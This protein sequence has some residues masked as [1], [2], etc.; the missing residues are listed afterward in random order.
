MF[1]SSLVPSLQPSLWKYI[2]HSLLVPFTINIF[3]RL[4][5]EEHWS[6]PLSFVSSFNVVLNLNHCKETIGLDPFSKVAYIWW[7]AWYILNNINFRRESF[8]LRQ[9]IESIKKFHK[10]WSFTKFVY[11]VNL[12][13]E[14]SP[15][16]KENSIPKMDFFA[17]SL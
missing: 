12:N 14:I 9:G 4:E 17:S 16:R 11:L 13:H 15:N 6:M 8:T 5:E 3:S 7:L 10:D 1:C 2:L